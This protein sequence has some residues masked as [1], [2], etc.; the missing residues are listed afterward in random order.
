MIHA[1]I[2]NQEARLLGVIA[3]SRARLVG[4]IFCSEKHLTGHL[5]IPVGIENYT[6]AYN[7]IPKIE[8]QIM[9]TRDKRMTKNVTIEPIPFYEVSN[10]QGG[11]T[12]IIG[13]NK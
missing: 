11:M 6:G 10:P 13:G 5:A 1:F 2:E 7:V 12:F 3:C 4:K 8:G 9:E